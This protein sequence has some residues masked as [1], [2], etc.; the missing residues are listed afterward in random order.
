MPGPRWDVSPRSRS[1]GMAGSTR[2]TSYRYLTVAG[3]MSQSITPTSAF[4]PVTSRASGSTGSKPTRCSASAYAALSPPRA[5]RITGRFIAIPSG[6]TV[7]RH[8]QHQSQTDRT[9]GQWDWG[10]RGLP[11]WYWWTSGGSAHPHPAA[12]AV[13]GALGAGLEAAV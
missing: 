11:Q 1:V 5:R 8:G 6:G 4:R 13:H 9:T 10:A 12:R 7:V 2:M 3:S